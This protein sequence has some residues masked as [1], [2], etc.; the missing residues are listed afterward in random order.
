MFWV[1]FRR[2]YLVVLQNKSPHLG[3]PS[4]SYPPH[5]FDLRVI[6]TWTCPRKFGRS[7]R[8]CKSVV[9]IDNKVRSGSLATQGRV[10]A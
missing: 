3:P 5:P 1:S 9:G 4:K 6:L 10:F 7:V 2:L 8:P